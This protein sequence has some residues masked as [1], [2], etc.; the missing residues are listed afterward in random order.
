MWNYFIENA[1]YSRRVLEYSLMYSPSTRVANY[2]DSTALNRGSI[3][4]GDERNVVIKLCILSWIL[5]SSAQ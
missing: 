3:E 5:F 1:R 2:S 4:N